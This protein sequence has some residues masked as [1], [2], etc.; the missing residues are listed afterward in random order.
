MGKQGTILGKQT[1]AFTS[2]EFVR[3]YASVWGDV[4]G[5]QVYVDNSG[6]YS[7]YHKGPHVTHDMSGAMW[8]DIWMYTGMI[9]RIG[10]GD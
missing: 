5:T 8:D 1:W 9:R 3:F 6:V 7:R 2:R 4:T 10:W